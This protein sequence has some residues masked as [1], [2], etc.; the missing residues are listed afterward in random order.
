[1]GLV[2]L[3]YN[4]CERTRGTDLIGKVLL[5]RKIS[6]VCYCLYQE[7]QATPDQTNQA[8]LR[9]NGLAIGIRLL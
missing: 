4:V 1:V 5:K 8:A 7:A 2:P 3:L 6:Q 9:R